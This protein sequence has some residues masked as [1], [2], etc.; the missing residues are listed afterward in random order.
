MSAHTHSRRSRLALGLICIVVLVV[1]APSAY[2]VIVAAAPAPAAPTP[3]P[4]LFDL[5]SFGVPNAAPGDVWHQRLTV[6][7]PT[8][9]EYR[10]S[11]TST[12]TE[13]TPPLRGHRDGHYIAKQLLLAIGSG[14][15]HRGNCSDGTD[16]FRPPTD[17]INVPRPGNTVT[18]DARVGATVEVVGDQTIPADGNES[19]DVFLH[20]KCQAGNRG[21]G[22][23][24][25]F[26]L[27]FRATPASR[28]PVR[29]R[30]PRPRPP[31]L[32]AYIARRWDRR[33]HL[34]VPSRE[35]GTVSD[36]GGAEEFLATTSYAL[37]TVG[38]PG[39][40]SFW[41]VGCIAV[42]AC[43]GGSAWALIDS[44]EGQSPGMSEVATPWR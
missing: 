16:S 27:G 8:P 36:D 42:L 32:S 1:I 33:Q 37:P 34:A 38:G 17:L 39:R 21:A 11:I 30:F 44:G 41:L 14:T 28:V 29:E 10:Y 22:G 24:I 15:A 12:L 19:F 23:R 31:A 4:V 7:N 6:S 13:A 2:L 40:R 9:V 25:S 35:G 3:A 5:P 18:S 26:H 43:L 20:L